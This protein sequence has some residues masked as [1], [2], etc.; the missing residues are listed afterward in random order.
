[1]EQIQSKS[2]SSLDVSSRTNIIQV[3]SRLTY[4][5]FPITLLSGNPLFKQMSSIL[6][7]YL[8]STSQ[9]H[10]TL[11]QVILRRNSKKLLKLG[12]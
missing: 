8:G 7:L 3:T 5:I 2:G 9:R 12:T 1:M 6:T 4:E 10:R 11:F